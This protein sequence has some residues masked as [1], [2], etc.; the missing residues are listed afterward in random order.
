MACSGTLNMPVGIAVRPEKI[1]I[2]KTRP[3]AAANCL[4]GKVKEIAYFGSY[5]TY[6]VVA[7][8]GTKVKDHRGQRLPA[9]I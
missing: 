5:N 4:Q 9:T 3:D 1:E 7:T 6:I 2:S 8:D